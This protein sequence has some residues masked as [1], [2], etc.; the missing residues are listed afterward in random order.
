MGGTYA[1]LDADVQPD[2]TYFYKLEDIDVK[3]VSTFH[4]P[5]STAVVTAPTAVRLRNVSAR[6]VT[7][8]LLGLVLLVGL[9]T[10]YTYRR[11]R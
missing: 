8:P 9:G 6:G 5:I 11:R 10:V 2:V 3:G 1:W 7:T 4:G